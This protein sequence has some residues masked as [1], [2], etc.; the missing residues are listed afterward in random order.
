[1]K[2]RNILIGEDIRQEVGNKFS[3]MGILGD[4]ISIDFH[5]SMPKE[6][7]VSLSLA[8]LISIENT[9]PAND[10][11]DF[12]IK[13][14]ISVGEKLMANM[15]ARVESTGTNKIFHLPVPRFELGILETS[16]LTVHAQVF[17][18]DTMVSENAAF[19]EVTLN[20]L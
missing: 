19:V 12:D 20:R 5:Q 8:C 6:A 17:K 7:P 10:P 1:M 11:K 18:N 13:I 9:D 4:S 15:V 14:A 16:K 3:L 2:V